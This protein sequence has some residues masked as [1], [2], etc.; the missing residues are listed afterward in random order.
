[1]AKVHPPCP[2]DVR[3]EAVELARTSGKG[4]P[5]SGTWT[6][7]TATGSPNVPGGLGSPASAAATR[8]PGS[9]SA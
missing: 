5:Q 9:P 3:A 1:M 4:I 7:P 2:P 8:P 6:E